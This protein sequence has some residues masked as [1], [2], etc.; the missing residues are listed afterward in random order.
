[1]DFEYDAPVDKRSSNL[2]RVVPDFPKPGIIFKDITPLLADAT[3]FQGVCKQMAN[4]AAEVDYIAGIEARGFIF[5]AAVAALSNKGFIP[6]RK[7]GKLPG[8]TFSTS[9]DL[10]Y[11]K[12]TLEIHSDLIP[13][14]GKVLLIDDV[15]ATGGTAVAAIELLKMAKLNPVG[16]TFVLEIPA[17]G[18][19]S[20]IAKSQP[21]LKTQTILAE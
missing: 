12:A 1:V 7:F 13:I 8:K 14:G 5:A 21:G 19:R 11:G 18:G 2:I 15:L 16:I 3:A 9:Y 4:Q 10:E 17:L 20:R 6:I